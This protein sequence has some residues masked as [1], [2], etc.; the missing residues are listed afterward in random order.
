MGITES[1][2]NHCYPVSRSYYWLCSNMKCGKEY[3]R[4]LCRGVFLESGVCKR[5]G[6]TLL[7][8]SGTG[9]GDEHLR[10]FIDKTIELHGRIQ[11]NKLRGIS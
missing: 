1:T 4:F 8:L 5:C 3:F 2:V 7:Q 6:A 11:A 9:V 10:E